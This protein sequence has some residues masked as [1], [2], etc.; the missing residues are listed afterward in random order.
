MALTISVYS[1]LAELHKIA[2]GYP[3]FTSTTTEKLKKS[4]VLIGFRRNKGWESGG[5]VGTGEDKH[6]EHKL[7]A[8][9]MVAIVDD[10]IVLQ[11]FGDTIFC[12]PQEDTLE[13][14]CSI[15]VFGI[16]H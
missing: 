6:L 14:N 16:H 7:L 5:S 2:I 10:A 12:A 11:Y 13:G 8:P 1:Y 3:S 9:D 4:P 15:Q